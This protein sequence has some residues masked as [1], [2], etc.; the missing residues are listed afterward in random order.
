M[1]NKQS[2][3][4]LDS[5]QASLARLGIRLSR[6]QLVGLG[7][8]L[9]A[10]LIVARILPIIYS[11]IIGPF[12]DARKLTTSTR[13]SLNSVIMTLLTFLTSF[14]ISFLFFRKPSE[15]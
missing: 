3:P 15:D 10:G 2:L 8:S 7:L 11:P 6:Q 9:L 12:L 13:D 1:S 4:S 5:I 14:A